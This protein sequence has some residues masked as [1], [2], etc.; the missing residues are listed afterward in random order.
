MVSYTR[1]SPN[2]GAVKNVRLGISKG[3]HYMQLALRTGSTE[4]DNKVNVSWSTN[5]DS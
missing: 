5:I 3:G 2:I 1:W 4:F